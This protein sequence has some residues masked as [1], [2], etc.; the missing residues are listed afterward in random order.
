[1][2]APEIDADG[3][4]TDLQFFWSRDP[5]GKSRLSTFETE[6]SP[7]KI[8]KFT[9]AKVAYISLLVNVIL[10]KEKVMTINTVVSLKAILIPVNDGWLLAL[11]IQTTASVSMQI[12]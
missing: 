8:F 3:S 7:P 11:D 5:T 6:V 9:L 10:T 1:M 2:T 4:F 12:G